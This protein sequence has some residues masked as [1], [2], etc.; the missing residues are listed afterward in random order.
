MALCIPSYF[1]HPRSINVQYTDQ[2]VLSVI[3]GSMLGYG[4]RHL[5]KFC[6]KK[7]L[8][9][10]Q[11]YVAQYVSLAL[12]TVGTTSLLGSD[13]L[14][15]CFVCGTA[16]AW[17]GFFNKQTEASVFSSVIDLLVN[18][19]AFVFVGAWMPFDSFSDHELSLSVGRLISIAVLVLLLRRL[20]IIIG[21]YK[22]IPD[23][24][25]FREA[26]F[27]GH[28]GPIGIGVLSLH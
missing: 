26:L 28:F 19:A 16:F 2:I 23:I 14:L 1:F 13:D 5:M 6:E 15:A 8:I 25:S 20:P 3:W 21:L 22:W 17:D 4:F 27:S 10:R 11:S 12:L 9:D 7:D 24:K 18:T